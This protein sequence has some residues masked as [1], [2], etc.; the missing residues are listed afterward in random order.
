MTNH[1]EVKDDIANSIIDLSTVP[2]ILDN[3]VDVFSLQYNELTPEQESKLVENYSQ[4]HDV[5]LLTTRII[6]R[7]LDQLNEIIEKK[8]DS[9][10]SRITSE[11]A[12]NQK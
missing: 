8:Y 10:E 6:E 1:F 9:D 11:S 4:I 2:A 7:T 3:L 5:L 12:K